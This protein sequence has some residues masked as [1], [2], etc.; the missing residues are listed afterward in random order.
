MGWAAFEIDYLEL[1]EDEGN[2][3]V[4]IQLSFFVSILETCACYKLYE[5]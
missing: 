4:Q 5:K 2:E 1:L 3:S